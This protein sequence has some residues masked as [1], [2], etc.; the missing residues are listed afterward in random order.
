MSRT[1]QGKVVTKGKSHVFVFLFPLFV[2]LRTKRHVQE[3]CASQTLTTSLPE[4]VFSFINAQTNL[5][6]EYLTITQLKGTTGG[7]RMVTELTIAIL[8]SLWSNEEL[9]GKTALV[10]INTCV[11][12]SKLLVAMPVPKRERK[13]LTPKDNYNQHCDVITDGE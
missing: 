8:K 2:F 7:D 9:Y 5:L 13:Y 1:R 3:S 6:D 4:D 10:D 11:A 12:V